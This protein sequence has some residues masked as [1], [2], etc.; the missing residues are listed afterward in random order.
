MALFGNG[1]TGPRRIAH[2]WT[3]ERRPPVDTVAPPSRA[4]QAA[5]DDPADPEESPVTEKR[6]RRS[7]FQ[8]HRATPATRFGDRRWWR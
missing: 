4:A 6:N 1:R 7:L 8:R 5:A 2:A 3:P